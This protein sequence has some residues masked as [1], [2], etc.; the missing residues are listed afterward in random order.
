MSSS[1]KREIVDDGRGADDEEATVVLL[2]SCVERNPFIGEPHLV[3]A[4]VYLT[5]AKFEEAEREAERGLTLMLEWGSAWDK[6]MSWEG[7]I[8][9]ARVLLMKARDRSW[10]QTSWGILNLGLVK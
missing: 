2:R 10:P 3:L 4:Q 7:W 1:S 8:A 9:W 5:K 6:R